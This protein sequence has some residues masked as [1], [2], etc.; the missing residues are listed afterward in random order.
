MDVL[1]GVPWWSWAVLAVVASA[2]AILLRL[3]ARTIG[4]YLLAVAGAA[5]TLGLVG[6][7]VP[8]FVPRVGYVGFAILLTV[9]AAERLRWIAAHRDPSGEREGDR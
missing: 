9:A 8:A 5:L 7:P 3:R 1:I 6:V 4:I 2:I